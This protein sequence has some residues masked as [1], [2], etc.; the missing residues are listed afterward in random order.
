[1][2]WV[3]GACVR[4]SKLSINASLAIF[5]LAVISRDDT[6]NSLFPMRKNICPASFQDVHVY[7]IS[8]YFPEDIQTAE[9]HKS[10]DWQTNGHTDRGT[11]SER[12][13]GT[14]RQTDGWTD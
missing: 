8:H 12:D 1:M 13:K 11:D 10:K 5:G 14:D 2:R 4:G 6:H 7:K 3:E 9:L